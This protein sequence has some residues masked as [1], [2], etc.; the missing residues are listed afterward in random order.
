MTGD[1]I[2]KQPR[3]A[4]W[5]HIFL[6]ELR[7]FPTARH[8]DQVDALSQFLIWTKSNY[9][10]IYTRIDPESG[11]KVRPPRRRQRR[12]AQAHR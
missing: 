1:R 4:S 8:D 9:R 6:S 11:R 2:G 5:L 10:F 3:E 12:A 7:S